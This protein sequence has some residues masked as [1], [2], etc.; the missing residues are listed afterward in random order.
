MTTLNVHGLQLVGSSEIKNV[1]IERLSSDPV[2][3]EAGRIWYNTTER[4][5][6]FSFRDGSGNV[7][8]TT[9]GASEA[10][11]QLQ[12]ELDDTQASLGSAITTSGGFLASAFVG[13]GVFSSPASVTDAINQI[14]AYALAHDTLAEL[15]DVNL[16]TPATG[17]LL[18]RSGSAWVNSAIGS[19]SGVQKYDATLESLADLTGSGLTVRQSGGTMGVVTLQGPSAGLT[20]TN[21]DGVAGNP[22]IELANDLAG[23]EGLATTGLAA[24]T[25]DGA[26]DTR[27]LTGT[28]GAI[29]ITNGNGVAGNPTID[30]PTVGTPVTASFA[31]ITTDTRGRVTATDAVTASD[32]TGLTGFDDTYLHAAGDSMTGNLAMNGNE[33]LGLPNI[34]TTGTA[35]VSK[36][37]L[38]SVIS[39]LSWKNAVRVASTN[40]LAALSG[41]Q[42]VDGVTLVAGDRV[43]VKN[44]TL[45]KDNGIY[46]ASA[47]A[48]SRAEDL[49][50]AGE[51]SSATVFVQEGAANQDS[52]WTQ[53]AT[54]S[55]VGTD[56]VNFVQ[57]SSSAGMPQAGVGISQTGN[58]FNVNLGA[59]IAQLPSDEVGVDI[60]SGTALFLTEDGETESTGTDA[61]LS[62]RLDGDT[63]AQSG[64][65]LKVAA[66]G[67]TG[68]E[69][70]VIG[71]PVTAS[72]VKV[73]TDVNGRVTATTAVQSSDMTSLLDATYVNV[74]G[75]TMTGTLTLAGNPSTNLEAAPKQYVDAETTRASGVEGALASLYQEIQDFED[76]TAPTVEGLTL[77][78][79]VN[80]VYHD[81]VRRATALSNSVTQLELLAN[82]TQFKT[83]LGESSPQSSY[84]V[85][86]NLNSEFVDVQ[87]W[88]KDP[89]TSKWNNDLVSVQQSDANTL[90]I[91]LAEARAV[92]VTVRRSSTLTEA[93]ADE[94]IDTD[95]DLPPTP[96][97]LTN[98]LQ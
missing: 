91:D 98:P 54:V 49:N 3:S 51:F 52:G 69:L 70:E 10:L 75:D 74:A 33:V 47:G 46:V 93:L 65:G 41:L 80:Y 35:A 17:D 20:I 73:T 56:S 42:T 4:K 40:N 2:V 34:P 86:H 89:V 67:I 59:G 27:T 31:K 77:A 32:V 26:W 71:T 58:T 22:T 6:K 8:V 97:I 44:Q 19:A 36:N 57:F 11:T 13:A 79:A 62:L 92:A 43:L 45:A 29:T 64:N 25:A 95:V 48:W 50:A 96:A 82:R 76:A 94:L 81:L 15:N 66:A 72:F 12:T 16:N 55:V 1:N 53:T 68:T 88:V 9:V 60:L 90:Q 85:A 23:L 14:A 18:I 5:L 63:L 87:V 7:Q 83:K 38:D 21:G 61:Q 39:G 37:Y 30:I 84:S 28:E 78:R 24:R